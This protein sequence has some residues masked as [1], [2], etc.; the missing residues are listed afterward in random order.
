MNLFMKYITIIV[1]I[2]HI[3]Y[4]LIKLD[5]NTLKFSL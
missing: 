1:A 3:A 4:Y 2:I 5:K